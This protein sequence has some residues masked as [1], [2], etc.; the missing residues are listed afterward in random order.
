MTKRILSVL[1]SITLILSSFVTVGF[2]AVETKIG[3]GVETVDGDVVRVPVTLTSLPESLD[4]L[5]TLTV[6]YKYDDSKLSYSGVERGLLGVSSDKAVDG[7]V[8]WY[9]EN[10]EITSVDN[11]VLFTLVFSKKADAEH[12]AEVE[13]TYGQITSDTVTYEAADGL[14][15]G[16]ATLDLGDLPDAEFSLDYSVD[17]EEKQLKVPVYIDSVPDGLSDISAFTLSY[18][19][20]TDKLSY[21]GVESGAIDLGNDGEF[22]SAGNIAWYSTDGQSVVPVADE[23]LFTLVFDIKANAAGEARIALIF[24]EAADSNYKFTQLLTLTKIMAQIPD[25]DEAPRATVSLGDAIIEDRDIKIP[26][27]LDTLPED[28]TGLSAIDVRYAFDANSLEYVGIE[29]GVISV[30]DGQQDAGKVS[31]Y[32]AAE[33]TEAIEDTILFYIL[34]KANYDVSGETTVAITSVEL[35]DSDSTSELVDKTD[36]KFDLPEIAAPVLPAEI[37]FADAVIEEDVV[38]V[39][40]YLDKLPVGLSDLTSFTFKYDYDKTKLEYVETLSGVIKAGVDYASAGSVSWFSDEAVADV[41]DYLF[42]LVFKVKAG[43]SGLADIAGTSAEASDSAYNLTTDITLGGIT[44]DI[45]EYAPEAE[46]EIVITPEVTGMEVKVP[47]SLNKLP[48]DLSDLSSLVIEYSYNKDELS[49]VGIQGGAISA[50]IAEDGSIVWNAE[51]GEALDVIVNEVLFVLIFEVQYESSGSTEITITDVV[52]SDSQ[53]TVSSSVSVDTENSEDIS[54]PVQDAPQIE[55]LSSNRENVV[56]PYEI[57]TA[58]NSEELIREYV[59]AR[60][61]IIIVRF[62]NGA[63]RDVTSLAQFSVDSDFNLVVNY[64]TANCQVSM[65]KELKTEVVKENVKII[66]REDGREVSRVPLILNKIPMTLGKVSK[67]V[68]NAQLLDAT[69]ATLSIVSDYFEV[70]FEGGKFILTPKASTFSLRR[71]ATGGLTAGEDIEFAN[72][73]L[74]PTCAQ[75]A[76]ATVNVG[77][78]ELYNDEGKTITVDGM[79]SFDAELPFIPHTWGEWE[80][81]TAPSATVNGEQKRTCSICGH[82][83][84]EEIPALDVVSIEAIPS[85]ITVPYDVWNSDNKEAGVENVIAHLKELGEFKV[86]ATLEDNSPLEVTGTCISPENIVVDEAALTATLSYTLRGD[87]KTTVVTLEPVLVQSFAAVEDIV[88]PYGVTDV[89][90][91]VLSALS[92]VKA[93]LTDDSEI[94]LDPSDYTIVYAD[95]VATITLNNDTNIKLDVTVTLTTITSIT[96]GVTSLS[97]THDNWFNK[98]ATEI[99]DYIKSVD[100]YE[101]I[102]TL[103]DSTTLDVTSTAVVTVDSAN[104]KAIV[105]ADGVTAEIA[106]TFLPYGHTQGGSS[107]FGGSSNPPRRPVTGG[108]AGIIFNPVQPET[109]IFV[110]LAKTHYAYEAIVAL[111]ERGIISGDGNKVYPENGI[112]RQEIAKVA[113]AIADIDVDAQDTIDAPDKD[114]VAAWATGYVATAIKEGIIKGYEDGTIQPK[115]VI[116]RGEM[117]AIIVRMLGIQVEG[118]KAAFKDV[119]ETLWSAPYITAAAEL[120]FVNGYEDGTFRAEKNITRAEAFTIY[121]RVLTFVDALKAAGK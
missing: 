16:N 1:L 50:E 17:E 77:A 57:A 5:S 71:A 30:D 111:Y 98:T 85:T 88:V 37:V 104:N 34:L 109:G 65:E 4:K 78:M 44:L 27:V 51:D 82:E 25:F 94:V 114:D 3:F 92:E 107:D 22:D 36:V 10:S 84:T 73:E 13:F 113:L 26:V 48:S 2:A 103:S 20:D 7:R 41:T 14:V 15:L 102:A 19:Y 116:T 87:T 54:I 42:T 97:I 100:G 106:L 117:V 21:A 56:I 9:Q 39:P 83:E 11:D 90:G 81:T 45:T 8:S 89:E 60:G 61:I 93:I 28:I 46:A 32:S 120:G 55:S 115:R 35:G 75:T 31:W 70:S 18:E 108:G 86:M 66:T 67:I 68:I 47:V 6:N 112:T 33:Y 59:K 99:A 91:Y 105:T 64:K 110:D 49:L 29:N 76:P 79:G 53:N 95:G 72:I 80:E 74:D 52:L 24:A 62:T 43:V 96:S 38:K 58:E 118:A 69:K 40:V 101:I 119:D 63:S 23:A 12:D 121:H